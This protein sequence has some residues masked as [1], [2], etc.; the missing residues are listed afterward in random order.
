MAQT[1]P[2]A[3]RNYGLSERNGDW[4]QVSSGGIIYPLDPRPEEINIKDIAA[5]LSKLCRY[6]GHCIH[7]I[8]V[9]E[10][11]VHVANAAPDNLKM[12]ALLHD[13]SEAYLVDMPRPIKR[14]FPEYRVHEE[15]LEKCIFEKFGLPYPIPDEV[16]RID[17]AILADEKAQ[18]MEHSD[19]DWDLKEPPLGIRLQFWN[20]KEAQYEFL[21]A[22]YS[23]GGK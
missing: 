15:R 21:K 11:S 2:R 23:Y 1:D 19:L 14:H 22:Y 12:A 18:N 5:A 9:A 6:G 7:Y 17:N 20:P 13:A 4:M 3:R 8:S 10:H 16:K